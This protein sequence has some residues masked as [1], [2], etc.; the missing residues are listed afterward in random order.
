MYY[1]Q[2][3]VLEYNNNISTT[4]T[5]TITTRA[6]EYLEYSTVLYYT[7]NLASITT[8]GTSTSGSTVLASVLLLA[9]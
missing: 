2:V 4:S 7:T 8:I 1:N 9:S 5:T 6:R 3:Q